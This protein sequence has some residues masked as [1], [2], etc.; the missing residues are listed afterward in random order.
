LFFETRYCHRLKKASSEQKKGW[1]A[2]RRKS[3]AKG[4][5]VRES[6]RLENWGLMGFF[7]FWGLACRLKKASSE[8]KKVGWQK[9]EKVWQKVIL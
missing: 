2:K 4:D 3:V 6:I 5:F 7:Q 9:D 8:Q 1:L